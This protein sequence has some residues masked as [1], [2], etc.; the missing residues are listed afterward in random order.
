[1]TDSDGWFSGEP[2][3]TA[4]HGCLRLSA[5]RMF[6]LSTAFRTLTQLPQILE[7]EDARIVSVA[8]GDLVGVVA[9]RVD[10]ERLE[11]GQ[12]GGLQDTER[13]GRL[14]VFVAASGARTPVPQVRP[15]VHAAVA[16]APD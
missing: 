2:E 12:L 8:P 14:G 1:M 16:V 6:S 9:D 15:G 4:A 7:R 3:A 13:I 10:A 5:K 11:R